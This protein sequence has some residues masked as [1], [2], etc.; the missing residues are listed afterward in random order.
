MPE[1]GQGKPPLEEAPV[2]ANVGAPHAE[3]EVVNSAGTTS[4]D[5]GNTDRNGAGGDGTLHDTGEL[6]H[7]TACSAG[8]AEQRS[9]VAEAQDAPESTTPE[10]DPKRRRKLMGG[11]ADLPAA[12]DAGCVGSVTIHMDKRPETGRTPRRAGCMDNSGRPPSVGTPPVVGGDTYSRGRAGEELRESTDE[13]E[14]VGAQLEAAEAQF[15]AVKGQPRQAS[16]D[17]QRGGHGMVT[18]S[19]A[20]HV[21]DEAARPTAWTQAKKAR[22][23]DPGAAAKPTP[24]DGKAAG[25]KPKLGSVSE[26]PQ[27]RV[28]ETAPRRGG[29]SQRI[30][31]SQTRRRG[32]NK[33]GLEPRPAQ[34]DGNAV[35]VTNSPLTR[36]GKV[37]QT[38]QRSSE[39]RGS[40]G[41]AGGTGQS[42]REGGEGMDPPLC[43]AGE[44]GQPHQPSGNG[45]RGAK[46]D[47][48]E[49]RQKDREG[50]GGM[51][52]PLYGA[53]EVDQPHKLKDSGSHGPK[54]RLS[55]ARAPAPK[56]KRN[57]V[58]GVEP[59]K[60]TGTPVGRACTDGDTGANVACRTPSQP[61]VRGG[62]GPA[63]EMA[64]D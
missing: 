33:P 60:V 14:T 17:D 29:P 8:A 56:G 26:A 49:T 39:A 27:P 21:T 45:M 61:W 3:P 12:S 7:S 42:D 57:R 23:S 5:G 9:G 50:G 43:G 47:W 13:L 30:S 18:R 15:E 58:L 44:W 38:H 63:L 48:G 46:K 4:D 19:R 35:E 40:E 62:L 55:G 51:D 36:N 6:R 59:A 22:R 54:R 64:P 11:K 10:E 20:R 52:P 24:G 25:N 53:G 41:G 34:G 31:G 2:H 1:T 16:A 28:D 37:A 32:E